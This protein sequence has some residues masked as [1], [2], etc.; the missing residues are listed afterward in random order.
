MKYYVIVTNVFTG[1]VI[2]EHLFTDK[3]EATDYA[4]KMNVSMNAMP[5]IYQLAP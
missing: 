3:S 2:E 4:I 1:E 5:L